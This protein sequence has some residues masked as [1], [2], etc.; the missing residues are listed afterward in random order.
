MEKLRH[1]V[2]NFPMFVV[3][4][5]FPRQK[6]HERMKERHEEVTRPVTSVLISCVLLSLLLMAL[7][8]L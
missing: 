6:T 8:S 4:T 5:T 3:E 1:S 2:C 7:L